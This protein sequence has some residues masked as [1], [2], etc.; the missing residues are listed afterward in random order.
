MLI[1]LMSL[2]NQLVYI[3][4]HPIAYMVKLNIE[5]SMADLIIKVARSSEID[6]HQSSPK[7][8]P[9]PEA[10]S[11]Q[12]QI[13]YSGGQDYVGGGQTSTHA[14]AV[15]RS[16]LEDSQRIETKGI[17]RQREVQVY[18]QDS[19]GDSTLEENDSNQHKGNGEVSLERQQSRHSDGSQ[20]PLKEMKAHTGYA[21]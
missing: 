18:I 10:N 16:Q 7:H 15:M 3:Q 9:Y 19:D 4:F 8:T 5:M 2:S 20:I 17:T 6:V 14:G 21:V 12:R 1:G 13:N 11:T